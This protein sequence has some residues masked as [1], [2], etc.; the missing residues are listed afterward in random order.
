MSDLAA[1]A[2]AAPAPAAPIPDDPAEAAARAADKREERTR[3]LLSL[4]A[5]AIILVAAIGPL[6]VMLL[7]SF[8]TKAGYGGIIWKPSLEGW[9]SVLWSRDI[10]DETQVSFASAHLDVFWR[11]IKLSL[12]TTLLTLLLGL[13]TAYFIATRAEKQRELWLFLITIPFWTNQLIRTFAIEEVIRKDGLINRVLE[14]TGLGEVIKALGGQYPLLL[15]NTDFA[16]GFGMTYVFLPLMVLPIYA[17]IEK[18][19]FRLVEAG[20]DLYANRFQ[21][22]WRIILPLVRPGIIAGSILVFIPALGAYVIPRILGGGKQMMIGNLIDLQFGQG[23]NWP[24]GSALSITLMAAVMIALM[25]YVRNAS[26]NR[27][28]GHG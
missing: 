19:D 2:P 15:L 27:S 18:L 28:S 14:M 1:P 4:P 10:F 12:V 6:L 8:M 17:S 22:L 21:V 13:P 7:Y 11:S 16:I 9:F 5:I 3:W 26:G 24:L 23:R 20:Y 25:V